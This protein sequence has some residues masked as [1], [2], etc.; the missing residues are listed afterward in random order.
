MVANRI[1]M[2]LDGAARDNNVI[3]ESNLE[4][5]TTAT[6][7][8]IVGGNLG[9][10]VTLTQSGEKGTGS[11]VTLAGTSYIGSNYPV[12]PAATSCSTNVGNARF[13]TID[14]LTAG[15]RGGDPAHP[16]A[17]ITADRFTDIVGGGMP[18]S[19]VGT[20]IAT[21]NNKFMQAVIMGTKALPVGPAKVGDRF[22]NFWYK[23]FDK[24]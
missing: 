11:I 10:F 24:K 16:S 17:D 12:A 3:T 2:L 20:I 18:P 9:W 23:L 14:F 6:V 1:Y 19:P 5:R 22:R 4:D 15:G 8:P 7:A 13:Y 21:G